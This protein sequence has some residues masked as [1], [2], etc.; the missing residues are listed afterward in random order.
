LEPPVAPGRT[1]GQQGRE[2]K[3]MKTKLLFYSAV[4]FLLLGL[5]LDDGMI[6]F[7][8]AVYLSALAIGSFFHRQ[9]DKTHEKD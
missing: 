3:C 4:I 1:Q 9:E 6:Y 5:F 8:F 7:F 2:H